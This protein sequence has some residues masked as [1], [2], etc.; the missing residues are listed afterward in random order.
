MATGEDLERMAVLMGLFV[1][2]TDLERLAPVLE[3]LYAD[4]DRLLAL[5][6]ED[7]EPAF[8]PALTAIAPGKAFAAG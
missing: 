3:T 4:L 7:V 6:T 1:P 8:A 2:R 5:P